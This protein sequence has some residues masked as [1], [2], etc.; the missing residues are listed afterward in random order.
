MK[1]LHYPLLLV[2]LHSVSAVA[3]EKKDAVAPNENLSK[4]KTVLDTQGTYH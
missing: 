3:Q 4:Y 1:L 2:F